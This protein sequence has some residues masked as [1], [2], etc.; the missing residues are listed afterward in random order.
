MKR[1]WTA[2]ILTV[3]VAAGAVSVHGQMERVFVAGEGNRA[4]LRTVRTGA[5]RDGNVELLSGLAAGERV[6]LMPPAGLRDGQ[7]LEVLP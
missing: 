4:V 1:A 2:T 7:P 5:T 3:L 6:V